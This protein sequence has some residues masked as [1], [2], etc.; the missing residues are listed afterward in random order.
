MIQ[1]FD[2]KIG[3]KNGREISMPEDYAQKH[4]YVSRDNY[5]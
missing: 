1:I 3:C 2:R 5:R 4:R